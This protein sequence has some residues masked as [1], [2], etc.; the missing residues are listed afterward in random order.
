MGSEMCIRDRVNIPQGYEQI[1]INFNGRD[2]DIKIEPVQIFMNG[3][4]VKSEEF[5]I[6]GANIRVYHLRE[7]Q[8][9]LSEIFRYINLDPQNLK[10]KTMKILVNDE[11]AGFTTPLVEGSRV[12]I[13]FEDLNKEV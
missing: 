8:V 5:L 12:K 3:Q 9:L 7:R 13:L 6:D 4:Q 11:P 10:G 2:I 1:R